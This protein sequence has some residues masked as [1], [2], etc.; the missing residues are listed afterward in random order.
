MKKTILY[1]CVFLSVLVVAAGVTDGQNVLDERFD[2]ARLSWDTGDYVRALGEFE[3]ILKS[4]DGSRFFEPIALL[5]GELFKTTEIT[6]DGRA[7]RISPDGIYAAYETGSR[8]SLITR[9]V[10]LA[11]PMK[12][13]AELRGTSFVFSPV[14][15]SAAFLRVAETP[16]I[17]AVRKELEAL[18]AKDVTDRQPVTAKQ[19]QLA[20]LEAKAADVY[21]YDISSKKERRQKVEGLLK[22]SLV[23]SADGR[24]LYFVGAKED[25]AASND[26][27][28][29]SEKGTVRAVTSGTGFKTNP[30]AVPSGKY[31]LYI[32]PTQTPFPK[33]QASAQ[34]PGAPGQAQP[35]A[36]QGARG[37]QPAGPGQ[38]GGGPGG[39]PRQFAVLDLSDGKA[40]TFTGT[41]PAVSADGSTLVFIGQDGAESILNLVKLEGPLAPVVVKKSAD[42][43]GSASPNAD[44]SGIVFDMT[45]TRNGE[46]FYIQSDG[47][48][49][50]R[51]SR[52]SE[53]DRAPRFLDAS[54]VFA[55]KGESRD[56]RVYLYDLK[57]P[58]ST[59][60]FHNNSLRTIAPEYEWV[61]DPTG[62]KLLIV[63]E[64]DGDTISG[65]R[66]VYCADLT[67]RIGQDDLIARLRE[68]LAAEKALRAWGEKT[69]APLRDAVQA[70]VDRV[71][72][73]KIYDYEKA[74]FDLDSKYYTLPANKLAADYIFAQLKS[75]GYAPEYQP[76]E[77]RGAKTQNVIAKLPGT[78]NPELLV[79]LGAHYDSVQ[80][81]PGADD[82][83]SSVVVNLETAR[84][85]AKTPLPCSVVFAFF[86]AEEAGELGSRE[87][88]RIAR[89]NKWRIAAVLNND[90]IGWGPDFRLADTIRFASYGLRDIQ[91]AAAFLFSNL[92][93]YDTHYVRSTDAAPFYEVYGSIVSGLGS[94]PVLGSPYYHQPTDLLENVNQ[95]LLVEAAKY[96]TA[97]VMMVASSPTPVK[98]LKIS[99]LK[100]DWAEVVWAPNPEQGI[101][102]YVVEFGPDKDPRA[103][104]LT[105]TEPR[106][107]L[108]GFKLKKGD[109]LAV[110]VKA[111]NARGMESYD[112]ARA[113]AVVK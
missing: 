2:T 113:T 34:Q 11:D 4:P 19:R 91:H 55:I 75:F 74:L 64:R 50:V 49:E 98:D 35:A 73:T 112:W 96:N 101:A 65:K 56:S 17:A 81:S 27:Y 13:V 72:I 85:L 52:E 88:I 14:S 31:F 99:E 23:F 61:A 77:I 51:L 103:Y 68:N 36:G 16:E 82:N 93:T 97:S 18:T 10:A 108:A 87:F 43:I 76:F 54:L 28:G 109:T 22:S 53:P 58:R 9:I 69:F 32:I 111:V 107:K 94:Y 100:N 37:G 83:S 60:V 104:R 89:E 84:L 106:A 20:W 79:V 48:N 25:D 78:E 44:G 46:I 105:A 1:S 66:G 110:A 86:T 8:P 92:V 71:S 3:A 95:R 5:T 12:T 15:N 41:S 63:A 42:R 7:V 38:R 62:T 70:A 40:K 57:T 67:K 102:S 45:Y 59:R 26:I 90:M 24:E 80:R 29:L 39:T 6:K 30:V 33:P 47:K 21:Y